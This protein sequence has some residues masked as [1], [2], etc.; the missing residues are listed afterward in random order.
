MSLLTPVVSAE[1]Q[2]PSIEHFD[3]GSE[4]WT[5]IQ[6]SAAIL[7][8]DPLEAHIRAAEVLENGSY[9]SEEDQEGCEALLAHSESLILEHATPNDR[10]AIIT[11]T[12]NLLRRL[13]QYHPELA[14]EGVE[15]AEITRQEAPAVDELT[16][17]P[18]DRVKLWSAANLHDIGNIMLPLSLINKSLEGKA[19][20]DQDMEAKKPHSFWGRVLV[21]LAGLPD[22]GLGRV[23]YTNHAKQLG[24]SYG[25]DIVLDE[26]QERSDGDDIADADR[27]LAGLTR[28][29]T[30]NRGR[31]LDE[32]IAIMSAGTLRRREDYWWLSP[33]NNLGTI[34][35]R[36]VEVRL[37][38]V[39]SNYDFHH[40]DQ[41]LV[42]VR[43]AGSLAL[44]GTE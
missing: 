20:T 12:L 23:I 43:R 14:I 35:K 41:G 44:V 18:R 13:Y 29:N 4:Y 26:G 21:R 5:E 27:G 33:D 11:P 9:E 28:D 42:A 15:V 30:R 10:N 2:V 19:W 16:G 17:A 40:T 6:V 36:V 37:D 32:R 1:Q 7:G 34:K 25:D 3:D 24:D 39:N 31:S 8:I 22:K 38:Y